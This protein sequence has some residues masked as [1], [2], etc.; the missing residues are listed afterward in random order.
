ML[1][2]GKKWTGYLKE[3]YDNGDIKYEGEII[4]GIKNGK[5]KEYLDNSKLSE[6][7]K[8]RKMIIKE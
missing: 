6:N 4:E 2:D 5:G 3:Y 7:I 1:L 8:K